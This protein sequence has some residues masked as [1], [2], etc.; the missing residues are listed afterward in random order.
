MRVTDKK[1]P[2][3]SG[4]FSDSLG[5]FIAHKRSLGY[6]YHA[7][8]ETLTMFDVFSAAQGSRPEHL[9]KELVEQWIQKRPGEAASTQQGRISSMRQFAIFM[10]DL[11]YPA[12]VLPPVRG[13]KPKVYAPY[14]FT[15]SEIASIIKSADNQPVFPQYPRSHVITPTLIRL[16]Y[17][18]GLRISE[19][20][21]LKIFDVNLTD[22]VVR[23]N[24][25][26]FERSRLV[27]LS[28]SLTQYLRRY[29]G[30]MQFKAAGDGYFFPNRKG[31][32]M[33]KN[34]FYARFRELLRASGISHGGR[35]K[36]PQLHDLRHTFSVHSI[37]GMVS[38][39]VDIYCALPVLATYL[40]HEKLS[41][42]GQYVRLT[43]EVYPEVLATVEKNCGGIF[44]EEVIGE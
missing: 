19:A 41:T 23:V 20:I 7:V 5:K 30:E 29:A 16:L 37:A 32:M 12:H 35:G 40:G 4:P 1:P 42:T 9:S 3:F 43:A 18:C 34:G 27:P 13:A 26:K 24:D 28:S 36:G 25:S 39:G 22:G 38:H 2:V 33:S 31:G 11:G 8:A 6:S 21:K 17:G 15:H 44:P 10:R 14:I